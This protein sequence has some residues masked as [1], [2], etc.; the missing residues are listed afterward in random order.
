MA[1][2]DRL[3]QTPG[4]AATPT[5]WAARSGSMVLS[6]VLM[7][8]VLIGVWRLRSPLHHLPLERDEGAYALIAA[9]WFAGMTLYRDLFD[10]KPPGVYL[11]YALA[12]KIDA[13]P[14]EAVRILATIWLIL[15]GA[16]TAVLAW[17]LYGRAAA[18]AGLLLTLVYS[19]SPAFDGLTFNSEAIMAL[20]AVLACLLV[21]IGMLTRR[22]WLLLC[23][24]VGV[25]IAIATKLVGVLLILPLALA[26]LRIAWPWRT[27]LAVLGLVLGA[28]ALP[29]LIFMALFWMH[30]ALPAAAEALIGYNGIYAA[31]SISTGWDPAWLWAI[32]A[33]MLP[34]WLPAVCGLLFTWRSGDGHSA[35]HGIA[36]LWGLAL[37]ASAVL[38]LRAYPH[39][40]VA[41][42]P[43]AGMWAGA[44][45]AWLGRS[46]RGLKRAGLALAQLGALIALIVRPVQAV[47]ELSGKIPHEQSGML[48][49]QDG[50]MYF[51]VADTV[52]A[53]VRQ[54]VRPGRPIFVWAAEPEIYYLAERAPATRFVYDY[55]IE[56][57]PGAR[58]E[59]I[60]ALRTTRPA[61]IIT[62]HGVQPIG[63]GSLL[64][65]DGYRLRKTI[66]GY[67]IY[68]RP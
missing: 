13:A 42:T 58:E 25:G 23:G 26:P 18:L 34:L 10:H 28:A 53:Y 68:E 56:R 9:H 30:D 20:P 49:G 47:R 60:R 3:E 2:D 45:I 36:A 19:S 55:P 29:L 32:W 50:W 1:S 59:V 54:H 65:E 38:S 40:Y 11:V 14:V 51:G 8:V 12:T 57:L 24:G 5:A 48:Y 41:A 33:P 67:D 43:F 39:Y 16:A 66:A 35:A 61:L 22:R 46:A 52:A 63:F 17:R 31:E 15:V 6:L 64:A 4:R 21:I 27:R 62:Y 37:L 44:G 7:L